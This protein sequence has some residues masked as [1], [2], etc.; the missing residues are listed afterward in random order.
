MHDTISNKKQ[1]KLASASK[2]YLLH[3]TISTKVVRR[4]VCKHDH[5]RQTLIRLPVS[6]NINTQ[7][8]HII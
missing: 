6:L 8:K 2:C 1:P 5:L 7:L 3:G 4:S